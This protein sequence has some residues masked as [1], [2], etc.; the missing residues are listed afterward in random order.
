MPENH[1]EHI[2]QK[3]QCIDTGVM[4]Y[5]E[6]AHDSY[7]ISQEIEQMAD[8]CPI[9]PD[10]CEIIGLTSHIYYVG[11]LLDNSHIDSTS[12]TDELDVAQEQLDELRH[13]KAK[14]EEALQYYTRL[15][16]LVDEW[17]TTTH[18]VIKAERQLRDIFH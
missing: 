14:I 9:L 6:L 16:T 15:E 18:A 2:E 12:L 1:N 4:A 5:L 3:L 17:I 7:T 13:S 11:R 8:N 10:C